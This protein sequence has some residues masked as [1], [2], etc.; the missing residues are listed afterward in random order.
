MRNY[1]FRG[2]DATGQKGW[3]YGDLVHNQKITATGLEPRMMVGGYEVIP[4]SVGQHTGLVD[5]AGRSVYEGDILRLHL[6]MATTIGSVVYDDHH[7]CYVFVDKN[8]RYS[9]NGLLPCDIEIIG[10]EYGTK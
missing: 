3:V 10:N 9:F 1:K 7:G 8:N 2:I 6:D 4:D 5:C